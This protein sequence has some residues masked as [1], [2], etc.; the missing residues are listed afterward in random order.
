[1]DDLLAEFLAETREMLEAM[2]GELVAWEAEPSDRARLDTIFRFVHTV[3]G[4]C[5]FF[6][7]PRLEALSHAAE[8]ALADVRAGRRAAGPQLVTAVLAIIDRISAMADAIESGKD[9]PQGGDDILIAALNAEGDDIEV[10]GNVDASPVRTAPA[11]PQRTIRLPVSLLDDVMASV[12]DLVLAR[13]DLARRIRDAGADPAVHGPFER[14]NGILDGV[15]DA[16]TRMRMQRIEHLYSALPRLVR[17]LASELGKQVMIDLEGGEV[18]LDREMIEMVRDPLTHI[19]RNAIDHGIETPPQRLAAGKREI[20]TLHISA[21]QSGNRIILT[22]SDDGRGIDG[23]ALLAKAVAAGAL[24]NTDSAAMGDADKLAL[25]FEPGLSTASAVT[26]VSGRGVGMDVVRANIERIGGSIQVKSSPGEGTRIL[27]RL[28]L[29]LSI[30]PSLTV[31]SGSQLFA[32]PRSYVEEIVH[33]RAGHI[34]FAQAGDATLVTVR[35]RRIACLPLAAVLGL[36]GEIAPERCTLVLVRLAG[37]DLF[38]LACDRVLDHEE[39]VIKPLAP[40][41]MGTGIYTGSTLLDDGNPVLMLDVA[42]IAR[43]ANIVGEVQERARADIDD[44]SAVLERPGVAAMLF[45]GLD[46]RRK[47]VRLSLVRRIERVAA[48]CFDLGGERPQVVIGDAIFALAGAE[49]GQLPRDQASVLRLGDGT[50]EIAFV[51]DRIVDTVELPDEVV[52]A[53]RSGPVEGTVLIGGEPAD[54]LDAHWLFAAFASPVRAAGRPTCRLPAGDPW[55][56][57]ILAPLIENAGYTVVDE[58]FAGNADVAIATDDS[59]P[60]VLAGATVITLSA[61]PGGTLDGSEKLYRYDRA[62]LLA[63]LAAL[64]TGRAA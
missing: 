5:G 1:M 52:P 18:E 44:E 54:L 29:T 4:N 41:I 49:A 56:Q 39:L 59:E 15:R 63:R 38:A 12:S 58:T 6:D 9:F 2:G 40:A 57:T 10:V 48:S 17:D 16:V 31:Q 62:G 13:N 25:I 47:A 36:P 50:N 28:P 43:R 23:D 24:S 37:G 14:L 27:L 53:G 3:K 22:V 51:I 61:D 19:I 60:Q 26:A 35:G 32:M 34:E 20:G 64:R 30:I 8:D 11:G 42:G 33:G 46:G 7:F 55:A 45:V 21:R